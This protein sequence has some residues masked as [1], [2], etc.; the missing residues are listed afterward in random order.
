M[1]SFSARDSP[2]APGGGTSSWLGI[3]YPAFPG[4][5]GCLGAGGCLVEMT[6]RAIATCGLVGESPLALFSRV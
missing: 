5:P 1:I 2:G 6:C 3:R 4:E